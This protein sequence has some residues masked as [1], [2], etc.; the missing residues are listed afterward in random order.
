M[1]MASEWIINVPVNVIY[2]LSSLVCALIQLDSPFLYD[3]DDGVLEIEFSAAV[4][5]A[6]WVFIIV[7]YAISVTTL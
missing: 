5:S 4:M 1:E 3:Q 6:N 7:L 2:D